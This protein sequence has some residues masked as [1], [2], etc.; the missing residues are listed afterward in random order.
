MRN[1]LSDVSGRLSMWM[2]VVAGIALIGVMLL[3]GCDIVGRLFGRPVPGAYE[4]VSLAGGLIIG[5]A[6]P[7]TSRVNGHV[8]TDILLVKLSE[9]PKR[10]LA[11]MTR[12]IGIIIFL[13]A[14]YGMIF[15]GV[16]LK[17]TGEVTAVL[18]FP[19]YYAAYAISG[20][21]FMQVL[22]LLSQIFEMINPK[23]ER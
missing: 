18:S 9:T 5:L 23:S 12:L 8:S 1:I 17:Y 2:E 10:I 7:A 4:I 22:V 3:I 11:V 13:C 20:A 6:L 21:F 16:R 19:F 15:M 14:G